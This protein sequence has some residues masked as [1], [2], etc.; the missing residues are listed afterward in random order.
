MW[1]A[2]SAPAL[3]SCYFKCCSGNLSRIKCVFIYIWHNVN[4]N[5]T[6]KRYITNF[7]HTQQLH[8]KQQQRHNNAFWTINYGLEIGAIFLYFNVCTFP[9]LV[10][11]VKS[12][13]NCSYSRIFKHSKT[14]LN[15]L[16]MEYAMK[17]QNWLFLSKLPELH[18]SEKTF[19][20]L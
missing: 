12:I 4:N 15:F 6:F 2:G 17:F 16:I 14:I 20:I 8:L 9:L 5:V 13:G 11:V 7:S 10:F 3:R 1:G 19:E 18:I